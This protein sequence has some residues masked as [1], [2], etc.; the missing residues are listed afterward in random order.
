MPKH[1]IDWPL[2]RQ[3]CAIIDGIPDNRFNLNVVVNNDEKHSLRV[4]PHHCGTVGCAMG[5]L[6]MH[7]KFQKLGLTFG[8]DGELQWKGD[9]AFYDHAGAELFGL[10]TKQADSLFAGLRNSDFDD[11][12]I[13]HVATH[14]SKEVFRNRVRKFFRRHKQPCAW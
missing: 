14:K 10:T 2:L 1:K 9:F 5:W 12:D 11:P 7:P 3:A 4:D 6:G 8:S 13:S